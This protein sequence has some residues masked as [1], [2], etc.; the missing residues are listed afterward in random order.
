M[1]VSW[2]RPDASAA[3]S[4]LGQSSAAQ[5]TSGRMLRSALAT[6]GSGVHGVAHSAR[7]ATGRGRSASRRFPRRGVGD[8]HVEVSGLVLTLL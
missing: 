6:E 7:P 5:T 2:A 3:A 4:P 8:F 1:T